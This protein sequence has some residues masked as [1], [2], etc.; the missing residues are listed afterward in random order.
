MHVYGLLP[1]CDFTWL[2]YE[3]ALIHWPQG[4]GFV[5]ICVLKC[6]FKLP[7]TEK[8]IGHYIGHI[9]QKYNFW[10]WSILKWL[11]KFLSSEKYFWHWMHWWDFSPMC[12]LKCFFY[13]LN[14]VRKPLYTKCKYMDSHLCVF[15]NVFSNAILW[16]SFLILMTLIFNIL[17]KMLLWLKPFKNLIWL[18][19]KVSKIWF[20]LIWHI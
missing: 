5:P 3:K 11:F 10:P 15:S 9:L 2:S 16:E 18:F 4:Y 20:D 17:E 14:L 1:L 19:I 13:N 7:F 8:A 12:V 6:L